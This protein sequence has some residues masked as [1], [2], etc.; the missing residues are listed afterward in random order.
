MVMEPRNELVL[1]HKERIG[2]V[3]L[4]NEGQRH[5]EH[6][7]AHR[8]DQKQRQIHIDQQLHRIDQ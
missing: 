6:Q 4:Q 7:Q 1:G 3:T 2:N 8:I 5:T